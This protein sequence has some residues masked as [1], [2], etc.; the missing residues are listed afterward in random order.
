MCKTII[1]S[2]KEQ[3]EFVNEAVSNLVVNRC[4]RKV[5]EKPYLCSTLLVVKNSTGKQRLVLN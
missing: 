2:A 3:C 5:K 1:Q 4:A